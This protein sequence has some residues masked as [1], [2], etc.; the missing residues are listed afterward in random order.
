MKNRSSRSFVSIVGFATLLLGTGVGAAGEEKS[1]ITDR[2]DLPFTVPDHQFRSQSLDAFAQSLDAMAGG[3]GLQNDSSLEDML[4]DAQAL[5]ERGNDEVSVAAPGKIT[6]LV[7]IHEGANA[8][9]EARVSEFVEAAGG[10]VVSSSSDLLN[11]LFISIEESQVEVV[12]RDASV[13]FVEENAFIESTSWGTRTNAPWNLDRIDQPSN[14]LDGRYNFVETGRGVVMYVV[15]TGTSLLFPNLDQ[16]YYYD[17]GSAAASEIQGFDC[18][19]H[20]THVA[21]TAVDEQFGVAPDATLVVVK[22]SV[23]C[24]GGFDI[25]T[26]VAGLGAIKNDRETIRGG[27]GVPAVVNL[28]L[29]GAVSPASASLD[30]QVSDLI[31]QGFTVVVAAGNNSGD[32]CNTSPARVSAAITVGATA[33]NDVRASFSNYGS[34]VDIFAPGVDVEAWNIQYGTEALLTGANCF[35]HMRGDFAWIWFDFCTRNHAENRVV[36]ESGTSMAAPLVA[37]V[38]ALLHERWPGVGPAGIKALMQVNAVPSVSDRLGSPNRLL[39]NRPP[40]GF[41]DVPNAFTFSTHIAWL[42]DEDITSGCNPPANNLFCPTRAVT[43]GQMAVFLSKALDLPPAPSFGFVDVSPSSS[44]ST[45]IDRL[46]AAGITQGCNPPANDRFCPTRAVTR[47][48]MAVFLTKGLG[49]PTVSTGGFVDV[50]PSS[51]FSTHI[52]R[53]AAAGIT[54]GC[55]PPV[56]DRFCPTRPVTRGQMAAFLRNG[57]LR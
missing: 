52:N 38:A 41:F 11:F 20:G 44:F 15:D 45:H 9:D 51:T 8:A 26:V 28:S 4:R 10:S 39:Q 55:N 36:L 7:K 24:S 14:R 42:A 22:A 53:L 34:C 19:G 37:G 49:L 2:E 56:N 57:V 43:R 3:P 32:A 13:E 46:A 16:I 47:G 21:S 17:D 25:A 33:Q 29:G 40:S 31:S 12:L 30:A 27:A 35:N 54:R 5:A 1:G 48:Q 18:Y 6:H 50:V 23:A